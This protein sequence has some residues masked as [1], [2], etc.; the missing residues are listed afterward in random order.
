MAKIDWN[1]D[2]GSV[3]WYKLRATVPTASRFSDIITPKTLKMSA[4]RKRYACEIIAARLMRWQADSLEKIE[5][6]AAGKRNEPIAIAQLELIR[7]VECQRVGFV[8]TNDLRFGASPDRV[9]MDGDDIQITVEAKCPTIP[10]QMEY[11]LEAELADMEP[12]SDKTEVYRCQRQGQLYIA[13][14]DEAIFYSYNERMPAVYVR[15]H[16]DE[17]FIKKLASA[18]EQFSDEL[19]MLEERARSRGAFQAFAEILSPGDI[20]VPSEVDMQAAIEADY[21]W[22]A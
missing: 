3:D 18:L 5:H 11:L 15:D 2:Q 14:A 21:Q 13:E 8:R 1:L 10:V 7:E 22:G 6:I 9:V 19:C 20:A 16:R 12:K 4:S 17:P